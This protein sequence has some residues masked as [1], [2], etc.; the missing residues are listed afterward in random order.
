[1]AKL[2]EQAIATHKCRACGKAKDPAGKAAA[3]VFDTVVRVQDYSARW[4]QGEHGTTH[5]ARLGDLCHV[6]REILQGH[7]SR[8][9]RDFVASWPLLLVMACLA[10]S[11]VVGCVAVEARTDASLAGMVECMTGPAQEPAEACEWADFNND[12]SVDLLDYSSLQTLWKC[13]LPEGCGL[14]TVPSR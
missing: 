8:A 14:G 2:P 3:V 10:M 7:L 6:C 13:A 9:V 11:L 1:M 5:T 4:D 12:G